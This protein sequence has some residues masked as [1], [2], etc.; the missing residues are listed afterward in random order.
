MIQEQ[1][2]QAR[3]ESNDSLDNGL[4]M[5]LQLTYIKVSSP[6]I[7]C[8]LGSYAD[9]F[10]LNCGKYISAKRSID[11]HLSNSVVNIPLAT[12]CDSLLVPKH[13]AILC[14]DWSSAPDNH[15]GKTKTVFT[16]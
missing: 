10:T 4:A 1:I 6:E 11:F 12:P 3:A 16:H 13:G 15:L 5:S 2:Y 8:Q 14:N 9:R 7:A